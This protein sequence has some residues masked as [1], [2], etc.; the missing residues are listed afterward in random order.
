MPTTL[1]CRPGFLLDLSFDDA[2]KAAST[3][4]IDA[5]DVS[6]TSHVQIALH[7]V[8]DVPGALADFQTLFKLGL[9]TLV[10]PMLDFAHQKMPNLA[11]S[12]H[13]RCL[14]P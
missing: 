11:S 1:P 2:L 3:M 13:D 5:R 8:K 6:K 9:G 10:G 4:A 12:S 14:S 7:T